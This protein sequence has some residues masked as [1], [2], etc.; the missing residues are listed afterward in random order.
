[1]SNLRSLRPWTA[2]IFC[3]LAS[4][5]LAFQA[6]HTEPGQEGRIERLTRELELLRGD[7]EVGPPSYTPGEQRMEWYAHHEEMLANTPFGEHQWQFVGPTNIS[8]RVTDV[9]VVEPRGENYT[10]FVATASGG[11]WRTRNEGVT[12]EPVFEHGPSTS[13]GDVTVAPSD[14]NIVYVGTGEANIFRSSHAGAGMFKS[15]DGGDTWKHIG[16]TDTNTIARILVHPTDPD[17]V[18]VAA[19][20]NEWTNNPERGVYRSRDGGE[21]WEK[22][23]YVDEKTGAIDL[24]MDPEVTTTLYAATWQRIRK[25]WNDPRNE[26]GYSGS[27]IHKSTDGGDTWTPVNAGLPD[28][29]HRGRIGIDLCASQPQTLYAFVDNYATDEEGPVSGLD[30]YGR[31]RTRGSILGAT[32]FRSDDGAATW[33]QVSEHDRF[34]RGM[35]ATYGWVFGQVRVDPNDPDTVYLMGLA[36][37]KSTDSGKSFTRLRGMHG[38]HHALWIDPQNSDY[39]VNGND[40]GVVISY[41]GGAR[42]RQF[43]DNLPAVQFFNVGIDMAEPFHVYGSIQDHGSRRGVVDFSRGRDRIRPVEFTRAPGGEGCSHVID[44]TD[45]DVVYSAGFYGRIQR[46]NMQTFETDR[47]FERLPEGEHPHRGQWVA[48]F[49]LSPHNPRIVY[50][51]MNHLFRSLDRGEKW[52]RISPDLSHADP[53]KMGDISYQTIF[54]IAESPFQ[55]GRIFCGT[56]DGRVHV[57]HDGG[58]TWQDIGAGL[59]EDRW[60]SEIIA[61]EHEANTVYLAQN[62]K[63]NDDFTPYLWKSTDLGQSWTSIVG[64][65]PLGTINVI[66]EDPKD[67]KMLYVGTDIGVYVSMDGGGSWACLGKDLP[68]TFVH[69]LQV[70]PRDDFLVAATHGRGIW[71]LDVRPLRESA[72]GGEGV[73]SEAD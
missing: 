54:S 8:G 10:I 26:V 18:Y 33:R 37:N 67:P 15:T 60:I 49:L 53:R 69:D 40:G 20:G 73:A 17:L 42:W 16:L 1:M 12:F 41:D 19:S 52:E 35:C 3:T 32:L 44:P 65:I 57:T 34:M 43:L 59:A 45:P 5:A 72:G 55:F 13:I 24:V 14:P 21:S 36:L 71:V 39:L 61:S 27:G 2:L 6:E 31:P 4:N 48:P 25:R 64:N 30:S 22:I 23:L 29:E 66:R 58:T 38:D 47:L 50:H 46:T 51:G 28:P 68:S 11:V 63:R 7:V 56:D 70:H 9:A 62:G